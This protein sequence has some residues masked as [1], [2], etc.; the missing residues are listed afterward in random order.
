[1]LVRELR[2][3]EDWGQVRG[4]A[5]EFVAAW[6]VRQAA[7]SRIPKAATLAAVGASGLVAGAA[8]TAA[9]S[10]EV[11]ARVSHLKGPLCTIVDQLLSR[12]STPPPS[13]SPPPNPREQATT[14]PPPRFRPGV[15]QG[16]VWPP[17]HRPRPG[18][19]RPGARTSPKATSGPA[20]LV[21]PMNADTDSPPASGV[22]PGHEGPLDP[23][24]DG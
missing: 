16:A 12:L 14:N 13:A 21:P 7:I 15:G 8:A 20:P 9:L 18:Y 5:E 24:A 10:P 1:M 3:D 22:T 23:V 6:Y 19:A 4:R 11:R 2:S 17:G